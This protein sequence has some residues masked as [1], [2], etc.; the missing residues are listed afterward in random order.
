MIGDLRFL[1]VILEIGV[2]GR[3]FEFTGERIVV[4]GRGKVVTGQR[5]LITGGRILVT[6]RRTVVTGR[7]ILVT[8]GRILVTGMES[9][10]FW[11]GVI[12]LHLI[13]GGWVAFKWIIIFGRWYPT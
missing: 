4:T 8:G 11:E 5:I 2:G 1:L 10:R 7:R 12:F 9:R 3:G 13:A 6:G